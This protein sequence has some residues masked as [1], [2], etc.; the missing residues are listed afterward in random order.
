[1]SFKKQDT[2]IIIIIELDMEWAL[3]YMRRQVFTVP[4]KIL[5]YLEWFLRLSQEFIFQVKPV[6]VLNKTYKLIHKANAKDEH[7]SQKHY[8]DYNKA[9]MK[10][11]ARVQTLS[12]QPLFY[13]FERTERRVYYS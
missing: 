9:F 11:H 13:I 3:K 12:E 1:M 10:E 5:L 4:M 2:V 6:F 7:L 8:K